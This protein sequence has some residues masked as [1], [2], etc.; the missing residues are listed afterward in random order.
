MP[1][2][3]AASA[4]P[5]PRS[6]GVRVYYSLAKALRELLHVT[7]IRYFVAL[8]RY[9]LLAVVLRR[10]KTL[11]T[12]SGAIA[13]HTVSHNLK[14]LADL[15][16]TRSLALIRPL[17]AIDPIAEAPRNVQVLCVGPRTGG[18]VLNLVAHGF[19]ARM[20]TKGG[21]AVIKRRRQKGRKR[22]A[23]STYRK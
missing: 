8:A 22:L 5:Q 6:F 13:Q 3:E 16:V 17:M 12:D 23:P 2:P 10:R 19:R 4:A 21:Q 1:K 11:T 15:A 18:E 20:Q 14:G 7:L 9:L